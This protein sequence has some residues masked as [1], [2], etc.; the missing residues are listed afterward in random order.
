[1]RFLKLGFAFCYSKVDKTF[2]IVCNCIVNH[3]IILNW[4]LLILALSRQSLLNN[5]ELWHVRHVQTSPLLVSSRKE[6]IGI[7]AIDW[8]STKVF[9]L[10]P[11]AISRVQQN[12][13]WTQSPPSRHMNWWIT[14]P[15]SRTLSMFAWS[16]SPGL[17]YV[18]RWVCCLCL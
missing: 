6:V 18:K 11:F 13:S 15:L 12:C 14:R 9:T 10:L 17:S 3:R 4:Y 8:K 2:E 7:D 5:L 16:L 1:M